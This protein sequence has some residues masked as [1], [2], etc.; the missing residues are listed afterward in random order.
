[1][2]PEPVPG[3]V[4]CRGPE[5]RPRSPSNVR[6]CHAARST[7]RASLQRGTPAERARRKFGGKTSLLIESADAVILENAPQRIFL[8][9]FERSELLVNVFRG[10]GRH[11]R[12]ESWKLRHGY[13]FGC[14]GDHAFGRRFRELSLPHENAS[15]SSEKQQQQT[16][17]CCGGPHSPA[18][19]A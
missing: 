18:Y 11:F 13:S 9:G 14:R 17:P 12:F 1:R 6:D 10:P 19:P 5:R 2:S 15:R 7:E 3:T 16:R 4:R 8:I